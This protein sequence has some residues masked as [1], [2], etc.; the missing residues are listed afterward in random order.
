M[1]DSTPGETPGTDS[2][3][4]PQETLT[5]DAWLAGQDDAIKGLVSENVRGLK[6]ALE[7][8]RADR[9][10][11]ERDL[12]DAAAKLAANSEER[13][14]LEDMA[15]QLDQASKQSS[16]YEQAHAAGVADIRLAWLACQQGEYF[17]KRG[18]PDLVAL[19]EA[20]P[21]LFGAPAA[22]RPA[23]N[24]GSGAGAQASPKP[25]MND[26]IRRAAGLS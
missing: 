26:F 1:T 2:G 10:R 25:G 6:T 9:K 17:T 24:A 4:T 7:A 12:R 19:K 21:S 14:R 22:Q 8:E 15:G 20:H 3:E 16:F 18:D 13:K 11:F 23:G 5:F